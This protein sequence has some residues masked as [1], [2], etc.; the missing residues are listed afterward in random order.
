M[1]TIQLFFNGGDNPQLQQ[2]RFN[3]SLLDEERVAYRGKTNGA[4]QTQNTFL[5][6]IGVQALS[7]LFI[8]TCARQKEERS[9]LSEGARAIFSDGIFGN[10]ISGDGATPAASLDYALSRQPNWLIDMFGSD[11]QGVCLARRIILRSNPERKRPGPVTLCVNLKALPVENIEIYIDGAIVTDT[12][13][14]EELAARIESPGVVRPSRIHVVRSEEDTKWQIAKTKLE[15]LESDLIPDMPRPFHLKVWRDYFQGILAE[16]V[17]T[18]LHRTDIFSKSSM[19]KLVREI[20]E[21]PLFIRIVGKKSQAYSEIDVDLTNVNCLGFV[22]NEKEQKKQLCSDKPIRCAYSIFFTPTAAIF[23]Y[24]QNIKGYNFV[25]SYQHLDTVELA[26]GIIQGSYTE[27]PDL[28]VLSIG[29]AA[30]LMKSKASKTYRPLMMM[31]RIYHQII[32]NKNQESSASRNGR[33]R[34]LFVKERQGSQSF[35]FDRLLRNGI[36]KERDIV[37]ENCEIDRSIVFFKES[38]SEVSL[39]N[40][41][42][43]INLNILLN[44]CEIVPE[45]KYPGADIATVL[46]AHESLFRDKSKVRSIVIAIRDAWLE[47]MEGGNALNQ[48]TTEMVNDKL[49]MTFL[50]RGNGLHVVREDEWARAR[51]GRVG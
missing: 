21:D 35:Y 51:I 37:T 18:V 50:K 45:N 30:A 17:T 14:L 38:N 20:K 31:P 12:S 44:N 23:L 3:H 27:P 4:Y 40:S 13:I 7:I 25:S 19:G 26:N 43:A 49:F 32:R 15:N 2:T 39:I 6:S 36:V 5:W 34:F 46:F 48:V 33:Q 8:L 22:E 41:F 42:P 10:G 24:L 9:D 47:L 28:C 1:C 16:H 29:G 11:S